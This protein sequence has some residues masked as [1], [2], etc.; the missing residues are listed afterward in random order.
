MYKFLNQDAFTKVVKGHKICLVLYENKS[1]WSD[2]L[3]KTSKM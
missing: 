2:S 3:L 1:K